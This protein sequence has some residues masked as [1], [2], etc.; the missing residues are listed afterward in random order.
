M[1]LTV[2]TGQS[3]GSQYIEATLS[4]VDYGCASHSQCKACLILYALLLTCCACR[5]PSP[6]IITPLQE[7]RFDPV[8]GTAASDSH[9]QDACVRSV[10]ADLSPQ[11]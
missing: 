6:F 4:S 5:D 8:P 9:H 11:F 2:P 7:Q 10:P 3:S 1:T